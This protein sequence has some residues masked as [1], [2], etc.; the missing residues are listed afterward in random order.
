[1]YDVLCDISA[2]RYYRTPPQV[3]ALCPPLPNRGS[4]PLRHALKTHPFTQEISG[5]PIHLL[6]RTIHARTNATSIKS[7]LLTGELPFGLIEETPLDVEVS[8]P[9]LTLFQM[10]RRIPEAHLIMAMYE[11]CGWFTVFKPSVTIES[12]LNAHT[13]E[14]EAISSRWRRVHD[15]GGQP[16]D[17]WQRPPLIEIDELQRFANVMREAR[18]GRIFWQAAQYVTGITASPFEVQASMLLGLPRQKG[19]E[20]FPQLQNNQRIKLSKAARTISGQANCYADITLEGKRGARP[21]VIECQGRSVH[22]GEISSISDS[23]RSTALQ[24]MGYDI[25]LLSYTQ[26]S[27]QRNFDIIRKMI[28]MKLGVRYRQK[29][30]LLVKRENALRKDLFIDWN[31]LG[32]WNK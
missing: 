23:N 15:V 11:F 1:M 2:F 8:S 14:L 21:L 24:Q 12:L 30:S 28:A 32:S 18:G 13:S 6:A 27:N 16:T 3:I 10:G 4:D 20:G 26:I 22:S 17:L 19:G 7:H 9:L 29:G 25:L 5:L 31:L